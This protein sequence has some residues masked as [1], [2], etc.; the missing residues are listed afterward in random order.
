MNSA[1][2]HE[3]ISE[4]TAIKE[5]ERQKCLNGEEIVGMRHGVPDG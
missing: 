2:I 5:E 3:L 1:Q 4:L